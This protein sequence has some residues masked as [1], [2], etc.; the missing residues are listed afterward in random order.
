[1][2]DADGLPGTILVNATTE[3]M[4]A[5]R[6]AFQHE[7]L[8]IPARRGADLEGAFC[9]A[10]RHEIAKGY[11]PS[12]I[13][14]TSFLAHHS[15]VG[16]FSWDEEEESYITYATPFMDENEFDLDDVLIGLR[17][18]A[19]ATEY[20]HVYQLGLVIKDTSSQEHDVVLIHQF[21]NMHLR[22]TD[23]VWLVRQVYHTQEEAEFELW[24]TLTPRSTAQQLPRLSHPPQA[25]S[26]SSLSPAPSPSSVPASPTMPSIQA[27]LPSA[28]LAP[29]SVLPHTAAN[30]PHR[31][32]S[33]LHST[34]STHAPATAIPKSTIPAAHTISDLLILPEGSAG[35]SLT[36]DELLD[37]NPSNVAGDIIFRLSLKYS[38]KQIADRLND[39]Y[40]VLEGKVRN[41]NT[42]TKRVSAAWDARAALLDLHDSSGARVDPKA[43]KGQYD[44]YRRSKG[45]RCRSAVL[46]E[47]KSK[48]IKKVDQ[49][50]RTSGGRVRK[51]RA[52][53]KRVV[54]RADDAE[55]EA[56][57]Q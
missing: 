15:A 4:D 27:V 47:Y 10:L 43:L 13:E 54:A 48:G 42:I 26:T 17:D 1:M 55:D 39:Q 12:A 20:S 35:G 18:L 24:T 25:A 22:A 40:M 38:N 45:L 14:V 5:L 37:G 36:D 34:N 8:S 44:D 16:G 21:P 56:E 51:S 3:A 46:G 57:D 31:I 41:D 33:N 9:A 30:R 29:P 53:K 7:H 28:D 19:M 50:D 11:L 6:S 23:T 49:L 52:P 2:F 32:G